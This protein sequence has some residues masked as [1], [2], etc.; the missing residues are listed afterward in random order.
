MP[1]GHAV[2]RICLEVTDDTSEDAPF[3]F[4]KFQNIHQEE[5]VINKQEQMDIQLMLQKG[6]SYF[7]FQNSSDCFSKEESEQQQFLNATD[8]PSIEEIT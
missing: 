8:F 2:D 4:L 6:S 3:E 1:H 5:E 7:S